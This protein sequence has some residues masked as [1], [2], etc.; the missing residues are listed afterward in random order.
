LEITDKFAHKDL[1][2]RSILFAN[3]SL[4]H[5]DG[6]PLK[7]LNMPKIG[8]VRVVDDLGNVESLLGQ[9]STARV[10]RYLVE[11]AQQYPQS[12]RYDAANDSRVKIIGFEE[13]FPAR[14]VP[15]GSYSFYYQAPELLFGSP[16]SPRADIWSLGCLVC[17]PLFP[18]IVSAK[19]LQRS[20]I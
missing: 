11:S 19:L 14:N 1:S 8:N 10:P 4:L 18:P 15:G 12:L 2:P 3:T 20:T 13:R 17:C 6:T 16:L 5:R 9:C 7:P